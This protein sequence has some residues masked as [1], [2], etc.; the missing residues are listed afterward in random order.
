[1]ALRADKPEYR[2][3]LPRG[4][5]GAVKYGRTGDGTEHAWEFWQNRMNSQARSAFGTL[6][7][8]IT[9]SRS[10]QIFNRQKFKQVEGDL[11]EFKSNAHQMRIFCF[12]RGDTWYLT[13]GLDGKKEDDLPR[14]ETQR[15]LEIMWDCDAELKKFENEKRAREEKERRKR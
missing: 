15:A 1:M 2:P 6:F 4:P 10:L 3:A 7:R 5:Y 8:M 11:Y 12:R 13:S 14:G 9:S